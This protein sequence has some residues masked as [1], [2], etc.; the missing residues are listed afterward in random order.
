MRMQTIQIR[1]APTQLKTIDQKVKEGRYQSRSEAIRDYIRKR[2]YK[3]LF[4]AKSSP[5]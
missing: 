1:L 4:A 3:K 2:L 5:S